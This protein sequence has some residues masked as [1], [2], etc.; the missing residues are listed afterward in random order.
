MRRFP[1]PHFRQMESVQAIGQNRIAG[2][3]KNQ[4][5]CLGAQ[6]LGQRDATFL[7]TRAHDHHAALGQAL[8]GGNRVGNALIIGNKHEQARVEAAELS[9]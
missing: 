2:S 1:R 8:S 9:C 6:C 3:Q 5:A 7:V 4:A